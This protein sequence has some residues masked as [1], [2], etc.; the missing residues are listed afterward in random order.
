MMLQLVLTFCAAFL[1]NPNLYPDGK[2]CLSLLGT[3]GKANWQPGVSTIE[4]IMV[5]IQGMIL[6][7]DPIFNE[8]NIRT[9]AAA[10]H[11]LL[12]VVPVVDP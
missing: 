7:A 8:V 4:Q 11:P 1:S 2:V 10:V 12:S 6:S 5:S 3:W 9:L